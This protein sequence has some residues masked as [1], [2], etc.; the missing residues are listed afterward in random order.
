MEKSEELLDLIGSTYDCALDP[1]LWPK[2]LNGLATVLHGSMAAISLQNTVGPSVVLKSHWNVSPAFEQ[3]MTDHFAI[4]PLVPAAYFYDVDEPFTGMGF[5]GQTAYENSR[6]F[7]N[8]VAPHAMGDAL[9]AL[10]AKREG[11]FGSLSLFREMTSGPFSEQ[12]LGTLKILAPHVR[13]AC[14]IANILEMR[15]L[16][17]ATL[18]A[19]LDLV[20]SGVV[21]TDA[22]GQIIH[23]NRAA[24]RMLGGNALSNR[25][26]KLSAT[27]PASAKQLREALTDAASG[28]T[29]NIPSEGVCVVARATRARDLAVWVMPLDGGLRQQFGNHF[30][31]SIAVFIREIGDTSLFP[32][33]LF[34]HRYHITPGEARVLVC[35]TQG[36]TVAETA[37]AQGISLA[38]TRTHI[39]RLLDKTGT[40]SQS[41]LMRLAISALAPASS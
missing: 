10:L 30:G 29:A 27:D 38:T 34:I 20:N 26:G 32:A 16:E 35:L 21:I 33:E 39:A 7:Q 28:T 14:M 17:S 6:W 36:M 8:A 22:F 31:A 18:T 25:N 23:A 3:S 4:N 1:S 12:S 5:M 9:I 19:T 41:D 40:R 13:R 37:D 11:Q 2:T 15:T 24:D